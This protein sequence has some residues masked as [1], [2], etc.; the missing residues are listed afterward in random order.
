[1]AK[2]VLFKVDLINKSPVD[3][4]YTFFGENFTSKA[5]IG[6]VTNMALRL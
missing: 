6:N 4:D 1:M 2:E 5:S 3:F